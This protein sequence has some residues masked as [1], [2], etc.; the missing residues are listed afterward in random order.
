MANY[1]IKDIEQLSGIKAHTLRIWEKRY[2][3]IEPKRTKTNIRYYDD[4]DLKKILNI[5]LLNKSGLKIS[6]IANLTVEKLNNEVLNIGDKSETHEIQIGSLIKSMIDFDEFLFE[7]TFNKSIMQIGFEETLL[8]VIYPF[9]VRIGVLWLTDNIDPAQEHF[10]SNLLRQKVISA[11]DSI[12]E[13]PNSNSENFVLFL[14]E[15]QWHEMGLLLSSYLIK[16]NGH[17]SIYLGRSLPYESVKRLNTLLSYKYMVTTVNYT[18][19]NDE[20]KDSIIGFSKEF[21]DKKIFY[22][23][24]AED[25]IPSPQPKNVTFISN[26]EEFN[27]FLKRLNKK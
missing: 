26:L 11:I 21:S 10:I 23:G 6:K 8:K 16:K 13:Y 18:L 17:R 12:P 20:I 4:N 7:K 25:A 5:S 9:F 15:D 27:T 3:I 24:V 19:S 14:Q 1:H 2:G 22:G